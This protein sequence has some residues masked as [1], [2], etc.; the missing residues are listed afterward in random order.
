LFFA[1]PFF[2]TGTVEELLREFQETTTLVSINFLQT[3]I[4]REH[5]EIWKTFPGNLSQKDSERTW[6]QSEEELASLAEG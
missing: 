6:A 3:W 4:F 2:I 5:V 1:A